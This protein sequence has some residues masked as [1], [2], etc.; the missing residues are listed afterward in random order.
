MIGRF[1]RGAD[2]IDGAHLSQLS[3]Q[4]FRD[5]PSRFGTIVFLQPMARKEQTSDI[6]VSYATEDADLCTN[7]LVMALFEVGVTSLWMDRL[8][9]EHGESIPSR[10]DEGLSK[11]RY[12]LPIVT[13]NYFKKFWTQMEL[14][15][16]RML[17]KP[18]LPIWVN[19]TA[20]A[21]KKFSPTLGAQKALIYENNPY[22]IAEKIG[23]TLKRNKGSHFFKETV[24]RKE[25]YVFWSTVWAYALHMIQG[26][27]FPTSDFWTK[28]GPED[29]DKQHFLKQIMGS[30]P[31]TMA[32]AQ[33]RAEVFRK[34]ANERGNK[35]SDEDI[36][37]IIVGEAKRAGSSF[38]YEPRENKALRLLGLTSWR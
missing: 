36:A 25:A 31:L 1:A 32:D 37:H 35:I 11:T 24:R 13:P 4:P 16:V 9:I 28:L 15:A 26:R 23:A 20:K 30:I 33:A 29:A 21:V 5:E 14:D 38:S 6:F 12:L 3:L 8:V 7:D 34:V 2:H 22:E 17:S 27:D 18:A 19:V 10:V